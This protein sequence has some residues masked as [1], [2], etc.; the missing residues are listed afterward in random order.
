MRKVSTFLYMYLFLG[1]NAY[2]SLKCRRAYK[3]TMKWHRAYYFNDRQSLPHEA[4]P[5]GS[6]AA[7]GVKKSGG[8][9]LI[10]IALETKKTQIEALR[11]REAQA[12]RKKKKKN[13]R[14]LFCVSP[15]HT[16]LFTRFFL[17]SPYPLSHFLLQ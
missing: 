5:R 4:C 9:T 15:D 11:L 3:Q 16:A 13:C 14:Y 1:S 6:C 10:I 17:W 2:I 12:S 8:F 7:E